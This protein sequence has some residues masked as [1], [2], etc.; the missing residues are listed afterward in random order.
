LKENDALNGMIA[1]RL[2]ERQQLEDVHEASLQVLAEVG[3]VV[4]H[5][6]ALRLLADAGAVLDGNR[7]KLF[8]KLIDWALAESPASITLYKRDKTPYLSLEGMN[9]CFGTGSDCYYILDSETGKRRRCNLHDVTNA[10]RLCDALDNIS[11]I[12][13]MCNP[14]EVPSAF[15]DIFQHREML[16][17]TTKPHVYSPH[18]L[19][20]TQDVIAM[21][22]AVVGGLEE[23]KKYPHLLLY[24]QPTSP[25]QLGQDSLDKLLYITGLGLPVVYTAGLLPG[26]TAPVTVAGALTQANAEYLAGLVIG[27]LNNPGA[28]MVYG[29]GY[30]PMDMRTMVG[31]YGAT[32]GMLGVAAVAEMAR[33]Y[34]K[35]S[36]GYAGCTDSKVVDQQAVGEAA[37]WILLSRLAGSNLIHD[38]GYMDSGLTTS[39]EMITICDEFIEMTEP[40]T[41]RVNTDPGA[42]AVEVIKKVG[43][44][45]HF[46][47]HPHTLKNFRE[48][49]RPELANRKNYEDWLAEGEKT[50]LDKAREKVAKI[51]KDHHCEPLPQEVA[52]ELD[53]IIEQRM[54]EGV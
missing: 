16:K 13:S 32:E 26:A 1:L 22:A 53:R 29:S 18:N 54:K 9:N 33:F 39:L 38:I 50:M 49:K 48:H 11:F 35:P 23:L 37:N 43:P 27:Q 46:L 6:K 14:S 25:L 41:R 21:S 19:R 34:N 40:F 2:F 7:V 36:W 17:H 24:A 20:G 45:G 3:V 47:N 12:M 30:T 28:P 5:E 10:V 8:P 44:G 52:A 42:L 4:Q 51:L 31:S 15:S